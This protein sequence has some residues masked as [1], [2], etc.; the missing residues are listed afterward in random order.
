MFVCLGNICRSPMA[1]YLFRQML[2]QRKLDNK[3]QVESAATSSEALGCSVHRGTQQILS[4]F[5]IRT[6]GKIA[7]QLKKSDY[8]EYD[9]FIGMEAQ[10]ARDM[11]RIFGSDSQGK[12]YKLL[13]FTASP[14]NIADPWWTHNFEATFSDIS[15]GL[16]KFL[17]FLLAEKKV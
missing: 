4:R 9:Y 11:L 17:E 1:E 15:F 12:V 2:I 16:E 8:S 5:G 13:D 6:E 10:N 3:I 14:R 7:V